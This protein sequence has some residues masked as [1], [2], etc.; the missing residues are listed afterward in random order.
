MPKF[1][2]NLSFLFNEH[3]FLER[4]KAAAEAGFRSVEY[5]FPY[6]YPAEAL[7]GALEENALQQVLFNLPSGDWQAGERGIAAHPGRQEE[8]R[9]GVARALAYARVL[10][11]AR[12]NCLAGKR[13]DGVTYEE[14]WRV[15]VEN[16]R[17]A[18]SE[19]AAEGRTL[20]VEAVNTFDIPNA[21]LHA[22]KEASRLLDEVGAKNLKLQ[23]DVYHMQ[24]MEGNLTE[25]IRSNFDGIGHI[26]IADVPGRHQPGSGEINYRFLL[27]VLDEMGYDGFVGLEYVPEPDTTSSFDWMREQGFA[28]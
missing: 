20:L 23:H 10:N 21:F 6:D 1:S 5:M 8:F 22:T 2:A 24:R 18:A 13:L 14:Q 7:K 17:Y 9:E 25:T 4:F 15:L 27:K 11:V 12:I 28:P 26:Q 3:P 19:L 16:L